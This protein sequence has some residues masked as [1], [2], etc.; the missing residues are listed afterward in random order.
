MH[1]ND[2]VYAEH[3]HGNSSRFRVHRIVIA[4]RQQGHIGLVEFADELHITEGAG[5]ASV[6][7]L[8]AILKL[9]YEAAW[10]TNVYAIVHA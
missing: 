9:D 3:T 8:A 6:I 7:E 10:L 4:D 5:V 2:M 1:G